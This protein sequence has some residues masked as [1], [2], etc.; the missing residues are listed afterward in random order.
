MTTSR[1]RPKLLRLGDMLLTVFRHR[2]EYAVAQI[3]VFSGPAFF[4]AEAVA[5][6]LRRLKKPF[7][8]T[9]HGGNLPEFGQRW[10]GRVRKLLLSAK[11]VTA[12]SGYLREKMEAYCDHI[13]ILPNALDVSA[14]PHR[15]RGPVRPNLIW[16]RSFHEIYNPVMAVKVVATLAQRY[17]DVDLNMV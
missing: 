4:Y 12:P 8:L 6:I 7:V 3:D 16:L 14:Y 9:L 2:H 17:P 1:K 11:A 5:W 10:P 15:E 13:Q